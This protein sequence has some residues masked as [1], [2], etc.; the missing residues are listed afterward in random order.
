MNCTTC[1]GK[2]FLN[3]QP[4]CHHCNEIPIKFY[5]SNDG[6]SHMKCF[7]CSNI[8]YAPKCSCVKPSNE[9]QCCCEN[10]FNH[11]MGNS[12]PY[13]FIQNSLQQNS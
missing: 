5:K 1:G 3:M 8:T 11:E 12:V 2:G 7:K 6:G 10:P 13:F 9:Q 4:F